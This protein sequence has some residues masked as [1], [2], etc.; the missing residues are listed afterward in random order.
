MPVSPVTIIALSWDRLTKRQASTAY[1]LVRREHVSLAGQARFPVPLVKARDFGMTQN[2]KRAE[3]RKMNTFSGHFE[4]ETT[5]WL[6][7]MRFFRYKMRR[8]RVK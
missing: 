8:T 7:I 3:V 1:F 6:V 2:G 5:N 4:T